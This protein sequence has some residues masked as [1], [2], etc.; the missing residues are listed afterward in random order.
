LAAFLFLFFC[1]IENLSYQSTASDLPISFLAKKLK[2]TFS[3][4]SFFTETFLISKVEIDSPELLLDVSNAGEALFVMKGG[5][6][7]PNR[8]T[9]SFIVRSIHVKEG[10]FSIKGGKLLEAVSLLN[11][12][13]VIRPNLEMKQFD[14]NFS[15]NSGSI[16][17]DGIQSKIKQIEGEMFFQT[18]KIVLKKGRV[19]SDK[20]SF[21][22][23]GDIFIRKDN[24]LDLKIDVKIPLETLKTSAVFLKNNAFLRDK[25]IAGV[26]SFQADLTGSY[27]EIEMHGQAEIPQLMEGVNKIG[28]FKSEFSYQNGVVSLTDLRGQI[29]SGSIAGALEA[30]IK[31]NIEPNDLSSDNA[32]NLLFTSTIEYADLSL[33]QISQLFTEED[34]NKKDLLKGII[35]SGN[36]HISGKKLDLDTFE[37]KGHLLAKRLPLFSP[38]LSEASDRLHRLSALFQE[39]EVSWRGYKNRIDI[40]NGKLIFPNTNLAFHGR[41]QASEGLFL[42]TALESDEVS[43]LAEAVK[44][45]LKGR[46]KIKGVLAFREGRPSFLGN[47]VLER[48]ILRKVPFKRLSTDLKLEGRKIVFKNGVL[49]GSVHDDQKIKT[50]KF[51]EYKFS[52]TLDLDHI[53]EPQFHFDV[54][55]NAGNPQDVFLFFPLSIPL[56]TVAKGDLEI[57]GTPSAFSVKGPLALSKGSLYGEIFEKGHVD[58]TVNKK[59]V[60][61]QNVV[62][63]RGDSLLSGEGAIAYDKTYWL[64]LEGKHLRIQESILLKPRFS[65]LSGE[66]AIT[67]FGK[68]SFKNPQFKFDAVTTSLHY[69]EMELLAGTMMADWKDHKVH[70][71]GNFPERAFSFTGE[72]ILEKSYPF[73]FQSQFKHFQMDTLLKSQLSGPISDVTLSASGELSASGKLNRL[74]QINLS[75]FLTE[76]RAGFGAYQ[77]QND[78]DL[79]VLA[80]EGTFTFDKIRFKGENTALIFN[81]GLTLL[82]EWNLFLSGEADLNLIT[83]FSKEVSSARGRAHLDLAI[84]DRWESPKIRGQL[85]LQEGRIRTAALSQN[86]QIESLNVLFNERQIIL[87][88]FDGRLG[89][90]DFSVTGKAELNGFGIESFG[91][92]LE[93]DNARINLAPDLPAT[94]DG[95]L[96]FQRRRNGHT[97]KGDLILKKLVYDKKVDLTAMIGRLREK[98]RTNNLTE[99]PL[100]GRTEINIHLAGDSGI[101]IANNI[102][103]IP[104]GI[105][106]FLKGSFDE[107]LLVGRIDVPRGNIFFRNNTFRVT[108]GSVDFLNPNEIDP[109]FNMDASSDVRNI[110]TDRIYK[111]DLNMS[112]TLSQ[113]TL[114]LTS[115]PSLPEDDILALL[116]IGKTAAD[117]DELSGG[118]GTEAENF[119]M[120]QF[121]ADPVNQ[122]TSIIGSPVEELTGTTFRVDPY[123]NNTESRST[124]GTRVTAETHLLKE[125]LLV[126]YSTTLD[127]SEE[128]LIRMVYEIN[129]N[130]SLVGDRDDTGQIGGDIRFRFEFR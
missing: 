3:P 42:E 29:F 41:W 39:G 130:I 2:V 86:I 121:L 120:T 53:N 109:T 60:L 56:Y 40:E 125:R 129:R 100:I 43:R 63:E 123:F 1:V 18:D 74:D 116:A 73:S 38:P 20:A 101:Q 92:F 5:V 69:G 64:K 80:K 124:T 117:L 27:P 4:A 111:I 83:F 33:Y 25:N 52:G 71:V 82:K 78:G 34:Q 6:K 77:V 72:I 98:K 81:G 102:A 37:A 88:T 106:L 62:L 91:F 31:P 76:L 22:A 57:E 45:P 11:I 99:M 65:Y 66:V 15:G 85:S 54:H 114:I 105:D 44:I 17:L 119:V 95:E 104:L 50:P 46:S 68:G 94:V 108:S 75:G 51:S 28:F 23:E 55:L 113:I 7:S 48:G 79:A 47:F 9:P 49:K 89:G 84:T 24:Q 59:E 118:A 112:G 103:N 14:V 128:D 67:F 19:I 93:L 26:F 36:L 127:P 12:S 90:G 107:P 122:I 30:K 61:L 97:L 8:S 13:S 58:L 70:L 126:L 110:V 21:F 32:E 115:F 96:F 35:V 10:Q 16:S 87:E